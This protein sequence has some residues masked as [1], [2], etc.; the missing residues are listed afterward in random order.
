MKFLLLLV[1]L[2]PHVVLAYFQTNISL[3][4]KKKVDDGL[5][6][7]KE[8][9]K[10]VAVSPRII[11]HIKTKIGVTCNIKIAFRDDFTQYGPSDRLLIE[12]QIKNIKLNKELFMKKN[13]ELSLNES[14]TFNF[15]S[16]RG[17]ELT[18]EITPKLP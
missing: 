17:D 13:I 8:F 12:V 18:L 10:V 14:K 6:L 7:T 16:K 5:I 1:L 11:T 2:L 4:Y 15:F 9:H 3:I